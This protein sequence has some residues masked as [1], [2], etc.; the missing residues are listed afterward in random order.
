MYPF[1]KK[2]LKTHDECPVFLGFGVFATRLFVKGSFLVEYASECL[3]AKEGLQREVSY[4]ENDAYGSF[5]F[6]YANYWY[7]FL[8][9][10]IKLNFNF[11]HSQL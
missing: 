7:V 1:N 5:L 8:Y 9:F 6:F 4:S 10:F 11:E 2:N 3:E